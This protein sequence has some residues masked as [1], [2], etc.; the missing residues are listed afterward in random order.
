M[1][2]YLCLAPVGRYVQKFDAMGFRSLASTITLSV[3]CHQV[4]SM[5]GSVFPSRLGKVCQGHQPRWQL[6]G[7]NQGHLEP[8]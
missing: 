5:T 2:W 1:G 8:D 4:R 7:E 6:Q 3:T